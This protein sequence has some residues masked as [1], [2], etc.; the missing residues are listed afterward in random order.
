[1]PLATTRANASVLGLRGTK[2]PVQWVAVA[3]DGALWT[4][5]DRYA[6]NWIQETS[7]FGTTNIN[8]V[9]T[10]GLGTWVAVGSGG[11]I[12]SSTNGKTWTQRTSGFGTSA[13]LWVAYGGGTWVAVGSAGKVSTSTDA[14]TWTAVATGTSGWSASYGIGHVAYGNGNWVGINSNGTLKQT[15]DPTG[16]W[17]TRTEPLGTGQHYADYHPAIGSGIWTLGT[18][19]GVS[20][21]DLAS[22][23]DAITW[24]SRTPATSVQADTQFLAASNSTCILAPAYDGTSW[25]IQKSTNGTSWSNVTEPTPGYG[26]VYFPASAYRGHNDDILIGT[27]CALSII[28]TTYFDTFWATT[29]GSTFGDQVSTL[30]MNHM[31]HRLGHQSI[32]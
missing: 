3:D 12:A 31:V 13:I 7:S 20:S 17:T 10:N 32:R 19:G 28:T 2:P 6:T 4:S 11:K 22:S 26:T 23:T 16:A 25:Q 14:T 24:T 30:D 8:A 1:M 18:E 5:T 15:T 9:A 29:D 21:G 27:K